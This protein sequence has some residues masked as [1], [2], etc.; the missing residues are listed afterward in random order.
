VHCRP[1]FASCTFQRSRSV[2][3]KYRTGANMGYPSRFLSLPN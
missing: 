2:K 1:G 3:Q